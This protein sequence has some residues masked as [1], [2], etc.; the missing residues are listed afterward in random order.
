MK[1]FVNAS[2]TFFRILTPDFRFPFQN[3]FY[4]NKEFG[5]AGYLNFFPL[6]VH[7]SSLTES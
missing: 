2:I 6:I 7:L 5:D 3:E 4:Q 1:S